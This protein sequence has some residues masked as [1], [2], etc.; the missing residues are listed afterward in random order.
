MINGGKGQ[1]FDE[2]PEK[3]DQWFTTTIGSLVK[4]VEGE[5]LLDLLKPARG[6]RI[7]DA[8]CGTG[9]FTQDI[10]IPGSTVLG[11][12]V[13]LPMLIRARQKARAASFQVSAGDLLNLPFRDRC[14]DKTVSV[15][16]LEFIP[17]GQRAVSE[18]FRV[19]RKG[20]FI[21][22][23]TLNSLSPWA[24]RRKE[25]ARKGHTL[26]QKIIFRSPDELA[27]LAPVRGTVRTAVHFL[28]EED[29]D[30]AAEIELDGRQRGLNTGAFLAVRWVNP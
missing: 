6:E 25:E 18:L 20:G 29:P 8:G 27:S 10:H 12:D 3:Y 22:V 21:V 23:A 16:A 19:T 5:L 7:L 28:K 4:K 24:M 14:F 2:W 30:R 13:S 15:T 1:L 11:L 9:V 26:F 17:D